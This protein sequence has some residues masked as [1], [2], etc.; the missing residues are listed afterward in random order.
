[1]NNLISEIKKCADA[2]ARRKLL[3]TKQ[4]F[5]VFMKKP[6]QGSF[7]GHH[8]DGFCYWVSEASAF[9]GHTIFLDNMEHR[10]KFIQFYRDI[11][12]TKLGSVRIN[13][14]IENP[15]NKPNRP[16]TMKLLVEKVVEQA[17]VYPTQN[18]T[19]GLYLKPEYWGGAEALSRFSHLLGNAKENKHITYW[20]TDWNTADSDNDLSMLQYLIGPSASVEYPGTCDAW[21]DRC[22]LQGWS[23]ENMMNAWTGICFNNTFDGVHYYPCKHEGNDLTSEFVLA[24][25]EV[26]SNDWLVK[27]ENSISLNIDSSVS[28]LDGIEQV[29]EHKSLPTNSLGSG[30][31]P[32]KVSEIHAQV[33][34]VVA[35]KSN[36]TDNQPPIL[37]HL[38]GI[39]EG[40]DKAAK[41]L[42]MALQ[43][44]DASIASAEFSKQNFSHLECNNY[45]PPSSQAMCQQVATN[46]STNGLKNKAK[47][48]R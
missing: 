46:I 10:Q 33:E 21:F 2:E 29:H 11:F 13:K 8:P 17:C 43:T 16:G 31:L 44:D 4:I 41:I 18:Y 30:S 38:H 23:I 5:S 39:K 19:T 12:P 36:G 26:M 27:L 9:Y 48:K 37:S 35:S 24:E 40:K 22:G 20:H 3:A 28:A 6:L 15:L 45:L 42:P 47:R 34:M 1:M 32:S 7:D 14:S 25:V